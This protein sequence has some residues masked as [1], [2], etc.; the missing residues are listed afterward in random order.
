MILTC[1]ECGQ[2]SSSED[3]WLWC[4]ACNGQHFKQQFKNWSSGNEVVDEFIRETQI[5]ALN[6]FQ[7]LEWIEY[8]KF[9][10]IKYLSKGGFGKVHVATWKEGYIYKWDVKKKDW[11]R[12]YEL[13]GEIKVVLKSLYNSKKYTSRIFDEIKHQKNSLGVGGGYK[14]IPC[15]GITKDP[16]SNDFVMVMRYAEEGNLRKY[17]DENFNSLDWYQK[18]KILRSVLKGLTQIHN[19]GLTHR[20]LHGGNIV[21]FDLEE[22]SITDFGLCKPINQDPENKKKQIFGVI[23]Y[24]APEV[25]RGEEYS[26]S[27]DVY[28]FGILM[29]EVAIGLPPYNDVPHNNELAIEII[30]GHRPKTDARITP[31]LFIQLF[32]RCWDAKPENRPMS[33]ELMYQFDKWFGILNTEA[34]YDEFWKQVEKIEE[35]RKSGSIP[36]S[37]TFFES[38]INYTTHPQAIYS[39][40]LFNFPAFPLAKNAESTSDSKLIDLEISEF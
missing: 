11:S 31:Q 23:P 24:I 27:S 19:A 5:N 14:I 35:Q 34:E 32:K 6:H 29:N 4:K 21:M 3:I 37:P 9:T 10:D 8:E 28:S 12:R 40:R 20:D 15:Y 1:E 7:K 39:S 18:F 30:Q 26:Q 36:N 16:I 33:Q 22:A 38:R 13:L 17:L 25:L 2:Q